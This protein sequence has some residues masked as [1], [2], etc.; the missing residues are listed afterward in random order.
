[1]A[2]RVKPGWHA[3]GGLEKKTSRNN[4]EMAARV[5]PNRYLRIGLGRK[6]PRFKQRGMARVKPSQLPMW[7]GESFA[8][9][10]RATRVKPGR[11]WTGAEAK[12]FAGHSKMRRGSNRA[13][14]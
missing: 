9:E 3:L 10:F 7:N 11:N 13:V 12:S 14:I 8:A 6:A 4:S 5:K 1:M 2:A